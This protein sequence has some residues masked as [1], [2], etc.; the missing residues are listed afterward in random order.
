MLDDFLTYNHGQS[1]F[2]KNDRILL[3][4]SG[5]VDSIVLTHLFY[6]TGYDFGIAH[7][8][9]SLREEAKEDQ[10]FVENLAK[11][12]R[13]PIHSTTFDTNHY[14]N[15]N[16]LSTQMAAR[17]LR[18][19]WFEK[20][21]NKHSYDYISTAHH[22]SDSI[23][24]VLFNF[25]KG[26]GISGIH[27]IR[28]KSG[29]VIRPLLFATKKEIEQYARTNGLR[30]RE[31][32]SNTSDKYHRNHIRHNILPELTPINPAFENTAKAT[33]ER[34]KDAEEIVLAATKIAKEELYHT[35]HDVHYFDKKKLK[36]L[37]GKTTI[38]HFLI[39]SFG[40]NYQQCKNIF[41]GIETSGKLFLTKTHQANVDRKYLIIS[42][43]EKSNRYRTPYRKRRKSCVNS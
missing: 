10:A 42:P 13:V 9:F 7:C 24:T 26:T 40:F 19:Q 36:S 41:S 12:C 31:D 17:K 1:L 22:H 16:K 11:D 28:P 6:Q 18:Y 21:T 23:E 32:R 3:A 38:L 8:N 2:E 37:S 35:A 5:G 34:L 14:A 39:K 15:Q 27:G 4:V 25:T 30:W 20:L 43:L 33:L 29:K